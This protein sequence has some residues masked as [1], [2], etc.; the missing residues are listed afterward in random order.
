MQGRTEGQRAHREEG[1][2]RISVAGKG[3]DVRLER[4]RRS[5]R[6]KSSSLEE[7]LHA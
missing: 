4:T 2:E 5:R 7:D 1:K 6:E 3:K